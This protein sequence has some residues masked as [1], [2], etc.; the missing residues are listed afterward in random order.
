MGNGKRIIQWS[1]T[2]GEM[3]MEDIAAKDMN[4]YD[5]ILAK[6]M[7]AQNQPWGPTGSSQRRWRC[8]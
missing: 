5:D 6:G 4:A 2:T 7:L 8:W 3:C 1:M